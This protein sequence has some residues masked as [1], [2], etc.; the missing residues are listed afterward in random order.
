MS[1]CQPCESGKWL[2]RRR[3]RSTRTYPEIGIEPHS[4]HGSADLII[5]W[6]ELGARGGRDFSIGASISNNDS[7]SPFLFLDRFS[8]DMD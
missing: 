5:G 1:R 7:W 2:E 4:F 8:L 6:V 3:R